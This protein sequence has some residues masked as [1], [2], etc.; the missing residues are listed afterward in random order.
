MGVWGRSPQRPKIL[1]CGRPKGSY[2]EVCKCK[3]KGIYIVVKFGKKCAVSK[4]SKAR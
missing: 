3:I 4:V 2:Y 1:A